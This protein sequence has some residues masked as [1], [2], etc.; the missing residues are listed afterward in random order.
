MRGAA[1]GVDVLA[2]WSADA[3]TGWLSYSLLNGELEL[4]AGQR[5]P[6]PFAVTHSLTAV[7]RIP[8]GEQLELGTTTRYATG[9]PYTPVLGLRDS[10][11]GGPPGPAYGPVNSERLPPYLRVDARLTHTLAVP[12]GA[13]VFYGEGLNLL[14]RKNVMAWTW[15]P[16]FREQRPIRSFFSHRTLIL[17]V[18]AQF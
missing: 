9:K 3:A 13:F 15:G 16:D 4:A 7:L 8:V 10:D 1:E 5:V 12:G 11:D 14:D 6:S 17:G 18:E 2:R